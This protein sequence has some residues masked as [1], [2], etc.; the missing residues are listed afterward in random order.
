MKK[1]SITIQWGKDPE[2][3][4]VKAYYFDTKVEVEAFKR[5]VDEAYER[6]AY[7]VLYETCG[8]SLVSSV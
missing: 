4:H 8:D 1:H 7:E 2:Y 5:G 6:E 3:W